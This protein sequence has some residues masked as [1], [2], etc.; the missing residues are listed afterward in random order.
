[1][2]KKKS[3]SGLLGTRNKQEQIERIEKL[4]NAP[5]LEL[6]IRFDA[7]REKISIDMIGGGIPVQTAYKMLDA[8]REI[9]RQMELKAARQNGNHNG[10]GGDSN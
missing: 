1:M 10:G 2:R 7:G 8:A 4:L 5:V 3:I 9:V 6:V